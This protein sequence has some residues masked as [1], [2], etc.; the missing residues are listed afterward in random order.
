MSFNHWIGAKMKSIPSIQKYMTTTPHTIGSDQT[1]DKAEKLMSQYH[2]RHLPVLNGGTLVGILSDRDIKLVESFRD[3]DATKVKVTE[4]CT[5]DPYIVATDAPLT[6]VCETMAAKRFGCALVCDNHKLVG[7][8]SWVDALN[9]FS[10][11]METRLK[12]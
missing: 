4:A 2:I 3:V 5:P 8:F 1:L 11:L 10:D 12:H 9:A 7:V 6:E